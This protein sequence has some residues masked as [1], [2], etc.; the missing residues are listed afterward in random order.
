MNRYPCWVH[1]L[2][3]SL[4]SAI[5]A[6]TLSKDERRNEYREA[7]RAGVPSFQAGCH[8]QRPRHQKG[9]CR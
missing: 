2:T 3:F 6:A 1:G 4:K 5:P 9:P 7:G 8:W